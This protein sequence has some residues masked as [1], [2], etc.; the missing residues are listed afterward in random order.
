[1]AYLTE[2]TGTDKSATP[3][4]VGRPRRLTLTQVLDAAIEMGLD[5]IRMAALAKRLNVSAAVL[6]TYV[7]G[8]DELVRLAARRASGVAVFPEDRGQ[9]WREYAVQ[10]AEA[11]FKIV[12]DG[13][14]ISTLMHGH[15]SAASKL[16]SAEQWV[17]VML[18]HGFSKGG[19]IDLLRGVDVIV[20]GGALLA[21]YARAVAG[22]EA[23]YHDLLLR[24][25]QQRASD[26]LPLLYDDA[27]KFA[28]SAATGW[29]TALASLL[30]GNA[31]FTED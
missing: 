2:Q 1:M 10:Y 25:L 30:D 31:I 13:Q 15:M 26:D 18:R 21:T 29:R 6:Y 7:S 3:R 14:L 22:S 27:E 8:R 19:A 23:G 24:T 12:E 28:S 9:S 4:P 20:L 11:H 5:S 17:Q 16:D